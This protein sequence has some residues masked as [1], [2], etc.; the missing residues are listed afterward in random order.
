M[1]HSLAH[2]SINHVI[3]ITELVEQLAEHT[4]LKLP[5]IISVQAERPPLLY[6][7][8]VASLGHENVKVME[9]VRPILV[10]K[11]IYQIIIL[12]EYVSHILME[13]VLSVVIA[14]DSVVSVLYKC[15]QVLIMVEHEDVIQM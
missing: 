8:L 6:G 10:V 3:R 12:N 5:H 13:S 4:S 9:E 2:I 11:H 15:L 14:P 1:E 7:L